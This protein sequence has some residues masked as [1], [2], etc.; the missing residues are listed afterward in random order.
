MKKLS[1]IYKEQGIAFRF[2]ITIKNDKGKLTY[3]ECVESDLCYKRKFDDKGNQ[4]YYEDSQGFWSE[5][6]YDDKGNQTYYEDE[7]GI[8]VGTPRSQSCDGKV[9]EVD[10]KKYQLKEL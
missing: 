2:P 9:V 5:A 3:L 4:T 8:V 6:E 1:E 10:G 7:A